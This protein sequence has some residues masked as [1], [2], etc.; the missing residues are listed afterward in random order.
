MFNNNFDF[1]NF[2]DVQEV[3]TPRKIKN[4]LDQYV[5]GQEKAKEILSGAVYNHKKISYMREPIKS[6]TSLW[7]DLVAAEKHISLRHLPKL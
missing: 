2:E 5:I 1:E 6:P 4:H 7:L 3:L